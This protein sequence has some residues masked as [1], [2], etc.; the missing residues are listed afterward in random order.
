MKKILATAFIAGFALMSMNHASAIELSTVD[1]VARQ[2][3]QVR[4]GEL[5]GAGSKFSLGK[6][7]GLVLPE[8]VVMKEDCSGLVMKNVAD[9]KISDIIRI[10]IDG[11]EIPASEFVGFVVY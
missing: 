10:K 9:P 8:G 4:M 6:L 5:T 1:A 2:G 7:A 3:M 11:Q